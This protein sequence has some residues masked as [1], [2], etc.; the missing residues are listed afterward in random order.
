VL[1][2]EGPLLEPTAVKTSTPCSE[3]SHRNLGRNHWRR[4][5][6][7]HNA[8]RPA[9]RSPSSLLSGLSPRSS[10]KASRPTSYRST[11]WTSRLASC[12]RLGRSS[13]GRC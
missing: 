5:T 4:S 13:A 2:R 10:G 8:N 1:P 3:R 12:E 11:S 9:R 6:S 7:R